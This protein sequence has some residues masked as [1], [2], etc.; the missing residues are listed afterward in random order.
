MKNKK[1]QI[2]YFDI[3]LTIM[4]IFVGLVDLNMMSK[5]TDYPSWT[6][7]L[8]QD[9]LN[10]ISLMIYEEKDYLISNP[11]NLQNKLENYTNGQ[12]NIG[13]E[14]SKKDLSNATIYSFTTN[15][16]PNNKNMMIDKKTIPVIENKNITSIISYKLYLWR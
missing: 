13:I 7:S 9:R 4:I 11:V 12:Y 3:L 1:G 5:N 15:V 10:D 16:Y 6:D 8:D 2:W 14:L